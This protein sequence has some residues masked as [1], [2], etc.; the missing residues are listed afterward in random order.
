MIMII[1]KLIYLML[2]V[3]LLGAGIFS[4]KNDDDDDDTVAAT[5]D[6][7]D[8]IEPMP[9]EVTR[10]DEGEP[11]SP[12]EI[13][14]FT[15]KITGFWKDSGYFNWVWW[16]SHGLSATY[17]TSMPDYK[18]WWQ[19][20]QASKV[21]N[22]VV[23]THTGGADNLTLRTCKVLSNAMAG[24]ML[25]GDEMFRR[26]VVAYSKGLVALS[27]GMEWGANDPVKYLQA[28]AVFN[29]NHSYELEGGRFVKVDYDPVKQGIVESWNAHTIPNDS[30]PYYGEIWLRTMRSKDDVPHMFRTIPLLMNLSENAEDAE[31]REWTGKALEYLTGFAKDI[32]DQGYQIRTKDIDGEAFIPLDDTGRV[33]DLASFVVFDI[34]FENAE[35]NQKLSTSLI[36]YGEPLEIECGSGGRNDYEYVATAGHYFNYAI[37]RYF[38]MSSIAMAIVDEY[39]DVAE[40]L[41]AGLFERADRWMNPDE[42]ELKDEHPEWDAD[43]ATHLLASATVG[44]PLKSSEARHIV[45]WYSASA[46]HYAAWDKWDPWDSS[47]PDGDFEYKPDRNGYAVPGDPESGA[48]TYIRPTEIPYLLEYCFSPYRN[49]NGAELVDCDVIADPSRWGE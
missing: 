4:C 19:D 24:Y 1:K 26:I 20:T 23:F 18:L 7:D 48:V 21:G 29:H 38:H 8:N 46:D 11:L 30:N 39:Y 2:A 22:T 36:A 45:K 49:P 37:V 17:D 42:E 34:I 14:A 32:V 33:K 3:V 12:E 9:W 31:V 5:D 13:T 43:V 16:T 6:D 27:Q 15:K 44:L 41:L 35:C 10:E 40:Q 47:L 28:R 25:S